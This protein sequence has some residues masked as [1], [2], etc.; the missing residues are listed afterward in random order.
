MKYATMMSAVLVAALASFGSFTPAQAARPAEFTG[1]WRLDSRHIEGSGS[2]RGWQDDRARGR[3]GNG[4]WRDDRYNSDDRYWG[5]LSS[6]GRYMVRNDGFLP[7]VIHIER[8][9]R[10]SLR[11]ENR[12]GRLLR[13]L[14]MG[15]GRWNN[16]QLRVERT[17][18]G[19]VRITEVFSLQNRGRNL[20]V[21]TTVSGVRGAR[22]FTSV[23]DKA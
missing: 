15:R 11:V 12:D 16:D 1:L 2:G 14:A 8:A 20:V 19:G 18:F 22:E 21:R 5:G 3:D 9:S 17:G 13:E 4:D 10:R 23:Y 6:R 7:E